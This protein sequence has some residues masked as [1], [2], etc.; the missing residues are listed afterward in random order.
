M[1]LNNILKY[2]VLA[3]LFAILFLPLYVSESM[4]FPFIT[5]K[6]FAFRI[7]VEI[8]LGAGI[9]LAL[10]DASYRP[11][12]SL[13]LYGAGALLLVMAVATVL[14]ENSFKSFW[15]NY[16]RMEGFVGLLHVFAYFLVAGSI[17]ARGNLWER[18][19]QV[20]LGVNAILLGY[21]ALQLAGKLTINQGGVRVDATFGNTTY[22]A[23]YLLFH[24]FIA[25]L[26]AV[27]HRGA[28]WVRYAYVAVALA[29][30]FML[31]HTA[32]RGAILGLLGGVMLTTLLI[33]LFE[34]RNLFLRK[35]AIGVLIIAVLAPIGVIALRDTSFVKESPVLARFTS[36]SLEETT[37]KSRFMV[38]NMALQ[39]FKERPVFGWGQES[40][41]FVFNK[42]YDPKMYDQEPWF[43]R[44]H[45]VFFDW[46]IAGGILG[47]LAYLSLFAVALY[48]LW[49]A[50]AALFSITEKSI[51]TGL[52]GGY[53]F[54]NI[55]VFD[56]LVSYVLF[57][58]VLAYLHTRIVESAEVPVKGMPSPSKK[59]LNPGKN[60]T[61]DIILPPVVIVATI[62][63]LYYFNYQPIAA[64]KDLIRA[65][66]Q[67]ESLDVNLSY[68]KKAIAR[69][70]M[71]T[72]EAREQLAMASSRVL[73]LNVD[74]GIKAQFVTTATEELK[75]QIEKISNDAR[76]QIF[77]GSFLNQIG[78]YDQALTYLG[79]AAELTSKK[80]QVYFEIASAYLN[81]KDYVNAV[82]AAKIAFD[83]EPAYDTARLVYAVTLIY[84]KDKTTANEILEPLRQKN[85]GT[86]APDERLLRA[87]IDTK[88]YK[89]AEEVLNAFIKRDPT[90]SQYLISLAALYLERGERQKAIAEIQKAVDINPEFKQQG[91]YYINEIKA[92][93]NP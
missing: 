29:D 32:T 3:G 10:R 93:R 71:G 21:G 72:V 83:L 75:K 39:G 60:A 24:I 76:H 90:N 6:N 61:Q 33:A 78:D 57:F 54:Q 67:Q 43:D 35:T 56:N 22:F 4:F 17:L 9:I 19:W 31:Y 11:K 40:F 79:K 46:L 84:A 53:F 16:E 1:T 64:N 73:S 23:V 80:Q 15:S 77:L 69:E 18:F 66:Q 5:G 59:S 74:Q 38:W 7:I 41:N 62:F 44:A 82:S 85:G 12:K 48:Y 55:F 87:Y 30:I 2:G 34:K 92:G 14:S 51:L 26:L 91:E 70:S 27:R 50:G 8:I 25:A 65:L 28:S 81:K 37:T 20:S 86:I 42:Y 88:D 63:A 45:N 36:I 47:L 58:A 89:G 52:L 49:W 68:F 13:I